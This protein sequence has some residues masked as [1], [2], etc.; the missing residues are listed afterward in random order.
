[1]MATSKYVMLIFSEVKLHKYHTFELGMAN[2]DLKV[3]I[4]VKFPISAQKAGKK[5]LDCTKI[6]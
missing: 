2:T 4:T 3:D 1:M 5:H 6:M